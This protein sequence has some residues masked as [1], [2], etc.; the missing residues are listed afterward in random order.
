MAESFDPYHVWLG[1]PPE[2]QP[3]NH[4]RL[5]GIRP[6]ESNPDVIDNTADQRMTHLRTFQTGK[7]GKLS[8]KL[9]NEVAA[10]RFCL[11]GEKTKREYDEKLRATL[12][13]ASS[14]VRARMQE[15]QAAAA[16]S[17]ASSSR[18]GPSQIPSSVPA[19][20]FASPAQPRVLPYHPRR[21]SRHPRRCS[22]Q[23][24]LRRDRSAA[25]HHGART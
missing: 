8:Q 4:Y 9:L 7:N 18:P 10:A 12:A 1:I 17:A 3:P 19:S 11:L 22:R 25:V 20:R 2:D 24:R 13:T 5:L 15:P 16:V 14:G 21:R 6:F 23:L